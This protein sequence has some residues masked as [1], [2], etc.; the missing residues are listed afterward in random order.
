[1]GIS[2]NLGMSMNRKKNLTRA[3]FVANKTYLAFLV[4][5]HWLVFPLNIISTVLNSITPA[6][7]A[8]ALK[9]FVDIVLCGQA[10][11]I[12]LT[13]I[14][15]LVM[16]TVLANIASQVTSTY[17]NH[18]CA[19]AQI[20]VKIDLSKC[21]TNFRMSFFDS[22]ER[23]D[24]LN[25]ATKYAENGGRQLLQYVFG[26]FSSVVSIIS[27]VTLLA[28]F[29]IWVILFLIALT[30][31]RTVFETIISKSNYSYNKDR[32]LLNRKIAY[33]GSVLNNCA[34]LIEIKIFDAYNF[35]VEKFRNTAKENISLQLKQSRKIGVLSV[36]HSFAGALQYIVLYSYIGHELQCGQISIGEYTLFFTT[37]GYF[38]T[39]LNNIKNTIKNFVPMALEAQNYLDL[40]GVSDY[41]KFYPSKGDSI[42]LNIDTIQSID[43]IDVSFKYPNKDVYAIRNISFSIGAGDLFSIVGINGSGK[44]TIIKLILGLYRPTSGSILINSIPIDLIS[45]DSLWKQCGVVFQ[46]FNV[47][48]ISAGENIAFY[49][50]SGKNIYDILDRVGLTERFD[51]EK[52]GVDTQLG[53]QFD[54][55]GTNLSGGELQKIAFAR[56]V[57]KEC[58]LWI[59]DEPTSSMD[60]ASERD[61]FSC[62]SNERKQNGYRLVILISHNLQHSLDA[63]KIL[64][65]NNGKQIGFGKHHQLM[66]ACAEYNELYTSRVVIES[67]QQ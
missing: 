55:N 41:E 46:K 56:L 18:A 47:F 53:R 37:V 24:I 60:A 36:I 30:L 13:Y 42:L 12:A 15:L 64:V 59:L 52:L 61:V 66:K 51:N 29:S 11:G 9:E 35:F 25:R 34:Q 28:P 26:V 10:L 45:R 48:S 40:L 50:N 67:V 27:V 44:S 6:V 22:P 65:L 49:E 57:Y 62:I 23:I 31:Y 38:N 54:T 19:N 2:A 20:A 17:T 14:I 43:F 3:I 4:K 8:Y 32:T 5:H 39:V 16:H 33:F 63:T 7:Y 21:I 58:P 1:M